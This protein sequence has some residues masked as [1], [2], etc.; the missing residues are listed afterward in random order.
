M[1]RILMVICLM[2]AFMAVGCGSTG[3]QRGAFAP[4]GGINAI[5]APVGSSNGNAAPA[6]VVNMLFR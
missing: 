6:E 3:V 2:A 5:A 4:A 1:K